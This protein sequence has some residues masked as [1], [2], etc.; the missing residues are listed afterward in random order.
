MEVVRGLGSSFTADLVVIGTFSDSTA[1]N[2]LS[3]FV[4][5]LEERML[6]VVLPFRRVRRGMNFFG[7]GGDIS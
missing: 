4:F 5:F 2:S 3:F 1:K 6:V 7:S